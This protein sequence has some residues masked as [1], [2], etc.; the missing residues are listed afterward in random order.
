MTTLNGY[1][2]ANDDTGLSKFAFLMQALTDE[3]I[4]EL[5]GKEDEIIGAYMEQMGQVIAWIGHGDDSRL[6]DSMRPFAATLESEAV[7]LE[8]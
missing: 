2:I 4:E 5:S 3:V 1:V 8:A 7:E 6:P